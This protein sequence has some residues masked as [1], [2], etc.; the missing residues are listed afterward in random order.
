MLF[1][2]ILIIIN[3]GIPIRQNKHIFKYIYLFI[4]IMYYIYSNYYII[5]YNKLYY[6]ILYYIIYIYTYIIQINIHSYGN[7][8]LNTIVSGSTPTFLIYIFTESIFL[9]HTRV[10]RS[11][12]HIPSYLMMCSA[13]LIN[14]LNI[15]L[16]LFYL[17]SVCVNL[18]LFIFSNYY[19][20]ISVIIIY[21]YPQF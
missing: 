18:N 12:L 7:Y 3:I 8:I 21:C 9:H 4:I 13:R 2:M 11:I 19:L 14:I 10:G 15:A 20:Y 5:I 1:I 6:I 17:P 16:L